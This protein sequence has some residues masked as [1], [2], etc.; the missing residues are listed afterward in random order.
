[1]KILDLYI[2][3]KFLTTFFFA[4]LLI[5]AVSIVIDITEK[6]EDFLDN[7]VSFSTVA[8]H[9][10]L[11]F[12]PY[13]ANIL[14][15]LIVFIAVIFFTSKMAY[16]SEIVSIL[17]SGI[18][19]YRMLVPYLISAIFLAL[20]VLIAAHWIVPRANQKR[21]DF[22]NTYL[23]T[24]YARTARNIHIQLDDE[25]YIYMSH[26]R[27]TDSLGYL[28]T[29]EKI[30]NRDLYYK[31]KADKI[32]WDKNNNNWKLYN[33][34]IREITS[35]QATITKGAEMNLPAI[36]KP[37][38]FTKK[39]NH[40]ETMTTPELTQF[41]EQERLKGTENL[42]VYEVEKHLRTATPFALLILTLIGVSIAS[43]RVRGGMGLHIAAG[44]ALSAIYI[45]FMQFSTTFSINGTLPVFLGVW[46]PNM[47]FGAL[48]ILLLR[49]AP[50]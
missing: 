17:G 19:F 8:F 45:L 48:A 39:F 24:H 26:Y 37:E 25:R 10:Y 3:K 38:D 40:K 14:S 7:D 4:I 34:E 42:E 20:L 29:L 21:I 22:E 27:S 33:Y 44:M 16:N 15:P 6:I 9:Y 43:R 1:M 12:I 11:N 31:L 5:V 41:I 2:I 36:F 32:G 18:S 23:Y 50:K 49:M 30:R 28:F 46:I 47:V 13:I 35:M